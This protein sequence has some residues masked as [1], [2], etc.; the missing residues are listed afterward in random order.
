[1]KKIFLSATVCLLSAAT[2]MSQNIK[3]DTSKAMKQNA[4]PFIIPEPVPPVPIDQGREAPPAVNKQYYDSA[5]KNAEYQ[6]RGAE[7]RRNPTTDPN[8]VPP[9]RVSDKPQSTEPV[10]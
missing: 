10:K 9:K 2:A 8:V 7:D 1:M 6:N 4:Q 3:V 5:I